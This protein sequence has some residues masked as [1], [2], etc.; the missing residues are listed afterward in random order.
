MDQMLDKKITEF[1]ADHR[2]EMIADL[3]R[4]VRIASYK[5]AAQPGAPL[6]LA[7]RPACARR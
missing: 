7:P 5:E 4:L 2:D 6:A 1:L 3:Q